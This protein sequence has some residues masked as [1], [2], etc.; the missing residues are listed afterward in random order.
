MSEINGPMS[1][2]ASTPR[3]TFSTGST[4]LTSVSGSSVQ[5]HL[6]SELHAVQDKHALET[7]ALLN[8]LADSQ[9]TS[10]MLRDENVELRERLHEMESRLA[11]AVNEVTRLQYQAS[12]QQNTSSYSRT[13]YQRTSS[14]RPP[15][16][17][18]VRKRSSAL[19]SVV[20]V[21]EDDN[22]EEDYGDQRLHAPSSHISSNRS[23]SES[24]R[25]DLY[26]SHP[27]RFSNSSSI[28]PVPPST[29]S[30]L[31]YEEGLASEA[32]S[33]HSR[34]P[35]SPTA[36]LSKLSS[37]HSHGSLYG[38]H[39]STSAATAMTVGNISPTTANFSMLTGS[40]GSLSL[41]PEHE[42]HLGDMPP[43]NLSSDDYDFDGDGQ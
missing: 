42:M 13:T 9:R 20:H 32:F 21:N 28:F 22:V 6:Q 34:S 33:A 37:R 7:G 15:D 2:S 38:H 18:G 8:A 27:K 5:Q 11:D 25:E 16:G 30:M 19:S 43:L 23:S 3:T 41:R 40:P 1:E 35:P 12:F 36:T 17:V 29:M 10:K 4:A 24:R 26:A 14:L 39:R 31:L